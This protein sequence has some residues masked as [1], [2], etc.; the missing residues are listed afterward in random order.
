ML[1]RLRSSEASTCSDHVMRYRCVHCRYETTAHAFAFARGPGAAPYGL[2][3]RSAEARDDRYAR[4]AAAQAALSIRIAPCP[5]CR[6]YDRK[7]MLEVYRVTLW[8]CLAILVTP[9]LL[10]AWGGQRWSA[11]TIVG[12]AL[13]AAPAMLFWKQRTSP[14]TSTSV[15][16]DSLRS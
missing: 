7:T 3:H 14:V 15:R 5:R 10:L 16:F 12:L 4:A 1:V 11:A 13:G 9:V 8:T 2:D 6:R